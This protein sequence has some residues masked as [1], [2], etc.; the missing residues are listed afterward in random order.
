LFRLILNPSKQQNKW[1]VNRGGKGYPYNA[2][3]KC[4]LCLHQG[5]TPLSFNICY[6]GQNESSVVTLYLE[7]EGNTFFG[8]CSYNQSYIFIFIF[9]RNL[10]QR[11]GKIWGCRPH[12][13]DR[14]E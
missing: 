1:K 7:A 8:I 9:L 10:Q 14:K 6:D 13:M 2:K 12:L 11:K 4:P 3:T 5:R